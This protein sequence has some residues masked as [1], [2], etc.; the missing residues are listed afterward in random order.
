MSS[1]VS[2]GC[3]IEV[4]LSACFKKQT[5]LSPGKVATRLFVAGGYYKA[6]LPIPSCQ[7]AALQAVD[8]AH[9]VL[10]LLSTVNVMEF[11]IRAVGEEN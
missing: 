6:S 4:H 2:C 5:G 9:S 8:I 11:T 1:P 10:F 7:L 3:Q